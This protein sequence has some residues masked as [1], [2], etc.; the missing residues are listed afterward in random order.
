CHCV[1]VVDG[2]FTLC[3]SE[4]LTPVTTRFLGYDRDCESAR[5]LVNHAPL[6]RIISLTAFYPNGCG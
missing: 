1:R 5:L 6:G 2:E 4:G 3:Y